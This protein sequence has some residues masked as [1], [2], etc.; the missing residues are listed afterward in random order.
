M[1]ESSRSAIAFRR[2]EDGC[3][4]DHAAEQAA[5]VPIREVRVDPLKP[6]KVGLG[7]NR[8]QRSSNG[9]ITYEARHATAKVMTSAVPGS[10]GRWCERNVV[11][12]PDRCSRFSSFGLPTL[13]GRRRICGQ[14]RRAPD[15][16]PPLAAQSPT[17]PGP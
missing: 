7:T 8:E 3:T 5:T 2:S 4:T 12:L 6:H 1:F 17:A 14:Q 13:F 9:L 11:T 16:L 10:G 15:A